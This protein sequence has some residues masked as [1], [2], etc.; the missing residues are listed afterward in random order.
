MRLE[1]KQ[2]GR[3]PEPHWRQVRGENWYHHWLE[4]CV[5]IPET[6][7]LRTWSWKKHQT[8]PDCLSLRLHHMPAP[9]LQRVCQISVVWVISCRTPVFTEGKLP[10]KHSKSPLANASWPK[11]KTN[12]SLYSKYCC[13]YFNALIPSK[14]SG[15]R[16]QRMKVYHTIPYVLKIITKILS[17]FLLL[18]HLSIYAYYWRIPLQFIHCG[19]SHILT[20]SRH[21]KELRKDFSKS[22]ALQRQVYSQIWDKGSC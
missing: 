21:R 2:P 15:P 17:C 16:R 20:L 7:A 22:T 4:Q 13:C 9:S 6:S 10:N 1:V 19:T 5:C 14:E 3:H 12:Y 18:C 11:R 8:M